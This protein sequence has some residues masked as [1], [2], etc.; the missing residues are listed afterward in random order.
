M[1]NIKTNIF[2][3]YVKSGR[4]SSEFDLKKMFWKLAKK[5]HPVVSSVEEN[6]KNVKR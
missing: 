6:Q 4:I 3:E 5:L 2:V 1:K